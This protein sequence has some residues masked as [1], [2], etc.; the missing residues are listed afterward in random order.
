MAMAPMSKVW[1]VQCSYRAG[2]WSVSTCRVAMAQGLGSCMRLGE[3]AAPSLEWHT[4]SFFL[5]SRSVQ[6]FLSF[7]VSQWNGY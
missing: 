5:R 3:V 1:Q 6:L 7:W 2:V 4:G